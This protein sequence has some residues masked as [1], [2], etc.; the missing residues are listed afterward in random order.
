VPS[1]PKGQF[2]DNKK[3][4]HHKG[5]NSEFRITVDNSYNIYYVTTA[6]AIHQMSW[7]TNQYVDVSINAQL[8]VEP[9]TGVTEDTSGS[10]YYVDAGQT[11]H[12][13]YIS[14][15]QWVDANLMASTQ[16]GYFTA[17]GVGVAVDGSANVYYVDAGQ[18]IHEMYWTGTQFVDANL[19]AS[20]QSGMRVSVAFL[21]SG[22]VT[23]GGAWLNG[24]SVTLSGTTP[25][26]TSVSQTTTTATVGGNAGAYSFLAAYGGIYT[27][28][29][30]LS[31]YAFSPASMVFNGVDGNQ[32]A[33]VT[34]SQQT[35]STAQTR[36]DISGQ[37]TDGLYT[38]DL[39]EAFG[40]VS[41][42][43][44]LTP[45]PYGS[46]TWCISGQT[47]DGATFL[48]KWTNPVANN[49]DPN[50][51]PDQEDDFTLTFPTCT[52]VTATLT[53]R[54]YGAGAGSSFLGTGT[55]QTVNQSTTWSRITLP[56]PPSKGN[57][58]TI[59][60]WVDASQVTLPTP[61]N[62]DLPSLLNTFSTCAA[63]LNHWS[64]QQS[65]IPLGLTGA[66]DIAYVNNWLLMHS[67]NPEPLSYL[68]G[69]LPSSTAYRLYNSYSIGANGKP[70]SPGT[71]LIGWTPD[72]CG[73]TV[74][75]PPDPSGSNN[76]YIS[77]GA[78][79]A[80][81]AEGRLGVKG[82]AVNHI[83]NGGTTPW[84]WSVIQFDSSGN[85]AL[86]VDHAMF[87]TYYVYWNNNLV[88]K[89]PQTTPATFIT[90]DSSY[91]RLPSQIPATSQPTSPATGLTTC[92]N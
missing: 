86:P 64:T 76:G 91:Q 58:V 84:I 35:A 88:L 45:L 6:Q 78:V 81:L 18:T 57:T 51:I 30:F 68:S 47:F 37:W 17:P 24:V 34:W 4:A 46:I 10:V 53:N 22:Q 16:S 28:V 20:S 21:I 69:S 60:A 52:S 42:T 23:S 80:Q 56:S 3:R 62:T 72:P 9:G 14:G 33:N 59:I 61:G 43:D 1:I 7:G 55:S 73:S 2:R 49:I 44:K 92:H 31:G 26:G 39:S 19:M 5:G 89:C 29:P 67:G 41:G 74:S 79:V 63:L 13:M 40:S 90:Q 25:S 27:A 66:A 85:L 11:V 15:G 71:A 12:K 65:G 54:I 36:S 82:Q 32:T 50:E 75:L 77:T 87:P 83:L 38:Y 48:M 8:L 70:A